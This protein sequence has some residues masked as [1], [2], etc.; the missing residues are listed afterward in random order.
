MLWP[1][2]VPMSS[3]RGQHPPD[4]PDLPRWLAPIPRRIED[5]GLRLAGLVAVINLLG[6]AFGFWYYRFQFEATPTP[7][8]PLVPDS[9]LATLFAAGA[10]GAFA[11]GHRQEWLNALAFFGNIILGFW[12]PYSLL[13]FQDAWTVSLPM[14]HFLF[15]SHLAMTVQAF[16]IYRFS[17]FPVRA[18]GIATVWYTANLVVDY[19]V[20]VLPGERGYHH[21]WVPYTISHFEDYWLGGTAHDW[22]AAGATLLLLLAVFLALSTRIKLLEHDA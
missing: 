16:V 8:L 21:T 14:F 19:F 7:M 3:L 18:V 2:S 6:T 12:T 9:P 20:P 17:E 13:L 5:L 22:L 4:A 1:F 10:F 11:L 15:W